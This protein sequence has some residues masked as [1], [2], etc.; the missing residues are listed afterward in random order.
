MKREFN[1]VSLQRPIL[2]GSLA[3]G[4]LGFVLPIYGK[5]LGATALEIGG[6]FSVFSIMTVLVR[7]LVGWALDRFGRKV[8][9][10]AAW[11]GYASAMALFALAGNLS[12]LYVARLVQGIASSFFWISAYTIAT[13]MASSKERG[14]AVGRVDEASNQ[15]ALYGAFAGFTVL[16]M[17]PLLTGWRVLFAGYAFMALVGA[18]LA[19]KNVPETR[20]SQPVRAKS[21]PSLSWPLSR[22]MAIVF[23]TGLSTA[24]IGPLLLIF[25]Q[26]RFTTDVKS[27]ALAYIPAALVYSFLPSRM[28]RLSDRF[29]RVPLMA[30]GLAGSGLVS[31]LLPGLSSIMWLV[32]LWVLEAIGL[33]AAA[34]AQE[35]LVADLTGNDVRGTGYGLYT[36]AASLGATFGPLIGG[37]L[38]DSAGH[39]V[40]FYLNGFVLIVGTVAVLVLLRGKSLQASPNAIG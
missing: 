25:L 11:V 12:G 7:P 34:P 39:A 1:P 30:I 21:K 15:G 8:F 4:I 17:L 16:S 9:F 28:G 29:G 36:F 35:A 20:P 27:L 5:Q 19:W 2:L 24:M 32:V 23:V 10:V 3:F 22:L 38:Y 40:P 26:D 13:D 33:T 14:S 31:L 18:W 37:W 6:L